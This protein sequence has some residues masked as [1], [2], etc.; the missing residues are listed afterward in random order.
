MWLWAVVIAILI[1]ILTALA[2][3]EWDILANLN[4][5]PRIP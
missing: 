3:S 1:A 4:T 2:G 5:F